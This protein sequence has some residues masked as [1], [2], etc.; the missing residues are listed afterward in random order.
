M[1]KQIIF[2]V[3]DE[4]K[5]I[6]DIVFAFTGNNVQEVMY[7]SYT[8]F[9][10]RS[11]GFV[12]GH[13]TL[14]KKAY[15]YAKQENEKIL[16]N[17]EKKYFEAL[18]SD[19]QELSHDSEISKETQNDHESETVISN[20]NSA[21]PWEEIDA[22]VKKVLEQ[23]DQ[24]MMRIIFQKVRKDNFSKDMEAAEKEIVAC[25]PFEIDESYLYD[26]LCEVRHSLSESFSSLPSSLI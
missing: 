14:I 5:D 15:T 4:L 2:R 1:T 20:D 10:Y 13:D 6:G 23:G 16:Q 24:D 12:P 8:D 19:M 7:N 9:V 25:I 18:S 22:I 17:I 3:P 11:I 21:R 26:V